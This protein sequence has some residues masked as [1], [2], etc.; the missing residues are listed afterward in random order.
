MTWGVG[1]SEP[2]GSESEGSEGSEEFDSMP[3]EGNGAT[4]EK[5]PAEG[6][7]EPADAVPE[8]RITAASVERR[9]GPG[10][11]NAV[12]GS[13][14]QG[15]TITVVGR[16]FDSSWYYVQLSDTLYGWIPVNGTEAVSSF[17]VDDL[18]VMKV[19]ALPAPTATPAPTD[20]G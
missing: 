9:D 14:Q 1:W 3:Q 11:Y 2:E 17:S 13:L 16:N 5:S 6:S 15:D 20:G 7:S 19:P 4:N 10:P 12:I 8:V 18:R